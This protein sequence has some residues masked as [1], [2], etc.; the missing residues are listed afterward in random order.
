M[1]PD[2]FSCLI[3]FS[4]FW[5]IVCILNKYFLIYELIFNNQENF[6]FDFLV[7]LIKVIHAHNKNINST[8]Y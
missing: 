8:K 4:L 7:V 2:Y 3:I 1:S 6:M 5:K